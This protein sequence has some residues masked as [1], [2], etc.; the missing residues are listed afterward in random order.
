MSLFIGLSALQSSQVGL[1]VISHN[2]TNANTPGYHRQEVHFAATNG[3]FFRGSPLG[4]G[5]RVSN[6]ER[7]RVSVI[8]SFLTET[9]SDFQRSDTITT[10]QR[11]V[12]NLF[13]PGDG[14]IHDGLQS[15]FNDI[16]KLA[17]TPSDRTARSIAV[18]SASQLT[19]QFRNITNNLS[20]VR[21]SL[22]NQLNDEINQLNA[23]LKQLQQL[24]QEI[25]I[26]TNVGNAP[27]NG[28]LD[29][30]DEVINSLAEKI[31]VSRIESTDGNINLTFGNF[32]IQNS[33]V[34]LEFDLRT[35]S[36]ELT[37][38]FVNEN[39]DLQLNSGRI[40]GLLDA[41]N[42]LLPSYEAQLDELAQGLIRN[43]DRIHATGVGIDGPFSSLTGSRAVDFPTAAL[44]N[45][46]A[47]FPIESGD[48]H[49]SVVDPNGN[50][51]THTFSIDTSTQ[52]LEDVI[53]QIDALPNINASVNA[54]TN[55]VQI[56]ASN[57]Y[58]FDFT[59]TTQTNPDLTSYTGTSVPDFAGLYSGE[60]NRN[61]S[62]EVVGSGNVGVDPD[63]SLEVRD[64]SG[65]LIETVNIGNGYEAGTPIEL[66]DGATI[67]L[68]PGTVQAGDTF[69]VQ[70]VSEPDETGLLVALGLN[71]FFTGYSASTI[72]VQQEILDDPGRF[73]ASL[74]GD[75]TDS[76]K[77]NEFL[78]AFESP[79][80]S[81]GR[82][83]FNEYLIEIT[84]EIGVDVQT[85]QAQTTS[86]DS[87]L[88]QYQRERDSLSGVDVNEE[89]VRLTQFQRSYEAAVRVI[90]TAEAVL[91]EL[92]AAV[93]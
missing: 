16:S 78:E 93:R 67:S 48:L 66:L 64:E 14:S 21:N 50:R 89:F 47:I 77:L 29:Q 58:K 49:L 20:I 92:F 88:N 39:R 5:V 41:Y 22:K 44:E 51:E 12:E 17:G 33:G 52:S 65:N 4:S 3:N 74:A 2:I 11:Q 9:I 54:Q 86:L 31:D 30:R 15:L 18:Q 63:L 27:P 87:L 40:A 32:S 85:S 7:I 38:T 69:D 24:N 81:D 25:R 57:G 34:D 1:D 19:G 70:L 61:L 37:L 91:D 72:G 82:L 43:F 75:T 60:I 71:S 28:L 26:A 56:N 42:E 36:N 73:S 13:L 76:V 35:S 80:L 68:P 84:T 10:T 45:S 55:R 46:G 83:T 8:E 53:N 79:V 90:Q 59:G 23:E 62:F 6:L